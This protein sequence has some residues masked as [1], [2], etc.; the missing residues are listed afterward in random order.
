MTEY[1]EVCEG[2]TLMDYHREVEFQCNELGYLPTDSF[3]QFLKDRINDIS[4]V[5]TATGS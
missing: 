5:S 2:Y 1:E 3:P 4:R